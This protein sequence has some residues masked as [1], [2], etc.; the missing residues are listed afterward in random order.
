[1][2][3]PLCIEKKKFIIYKTKFCRADLCFS[4]LKN[5]HILVVP[6]RHIEKLSDFSKEESKD[7]LNLCEKIQNL[8][9]KVCEKNEEPFLFK[10]YG[11]CITQNHIHFHIVPSRGCLRDL[12]SNFDKVEFRKKL[13]D[14][15]M[16]EL[17]KRLRENI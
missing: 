4:P 8:S 12:V 16:E 17:V 2:E 11:K 6:K 13:D 7:F 14:E 10:N 3:C 1:M 15:V 5:S 9:K